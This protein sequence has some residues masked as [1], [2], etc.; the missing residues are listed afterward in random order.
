[1]SILY[2]ITTVFDK[3]RLAFG[4]IL[5]IFADAR[6]TRNWPRWLR[7]GL[8]LVLLGLVIY[9][10]WLLQNSNTKIGVRLR[11]YL[12]KT[13]HGEFLY[14]WWLALVFLALYA[15]CWVG[16]GLYK[17][18]A[19]D[20]ESSEFPDLERSWKQAV[21][22]LEKVGIRLNDSEN[23]PPVY[24][25]LGR[26]IG[27]M[28]SLFRASGWNFQYRFPNAQNSRLYV[29]ACYEPYSV[30]VTVP[31]ATAWSYLCNAVNGDTQFSPAANSAEASDPTKT[32]SFDASSEGGGGFGLTASEMHEFKTLQRLQSQ[33][34]LDDVQQDRLEV[35]GN[36]I[37]RGAASK[38]QAFS[39][40]NE[41]LRTGERELKFVCNLMKR[42]RWPLCPVNGVLVLVPWATGESENVA[43]VVA[44]ELAN[45]LGVARNVP[46]A[47]SD[48]RRDLRLG[49]GGEVRPV[50][51][52]LQPGPTA[53]A[54]R[55][56]H[57][58]RARPHRPNPRD[59]DTDPLG[60]PLDRP[61]DRARVGATGPAVR[62]PR[63]ERTGGL[64]PQSGSLP[65]ASRS[66]TPRAAVRLHPLACPD[67]QGRDGRP[68]RPG[69]LAALRRVLPD[70]HRRQAEPS[71]IR[72]RRAGPLGEGPSGRG[73][74]AAGV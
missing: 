46:V 49:G 66:A 50:P 73:V 63:A 62:R 29:Y 16:Y 57:P 43:Q 39:I 22:E 4:M 42:D 32:L 21:A 59:G 6:D 70:G 25:V 47:L 26:P 2:F 18:F 35:L 12:E 64:A 69:G 27:G 28:D 74:D 67:R 11:N 38:T 20:E 1:M 48:H 45:N 13:S 14:E 60:H 30:F 15:L 5:P 9:G 7:W 31:D 36:K 23:A 65:A 17:L 37:H 24:L 54:N 8:H 51:Q 10:L 3:L 71:S 56:A 55:P 72:G 19:A 53:A 52:R 68:R 40:R 41:V 33:R 61:R 44:R 58:A 34:G